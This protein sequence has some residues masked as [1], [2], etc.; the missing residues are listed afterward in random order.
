MEKYPRISMSSVDAIIRGHVMGRSSTLVKLLALK[1]K[2]YS[3]ETI[4]TKTAKN[5]KSTCTHCK[6]GLKKQKRQ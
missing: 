2:S 6:E 5:E 1:K 4:K 3:A